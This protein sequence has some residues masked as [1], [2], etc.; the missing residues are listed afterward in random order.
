MSEYVS[1]SI[2]DFHQVLKTEKKWTEHQIGNEIVFDWE[3]PRWPGIVV[4]VYSS[5]KA[6]TGQ[7]RSKGADAIKVCGID[8]QANNG[9]GKG[10]IRSKKVYRVV[11]WRDNLQERVM[12]V[13]HDLRKAFV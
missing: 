1:I 11:N 3:L 6:N 9:R 12:D 13:I 10:L 8:L 4:R 7:S 5:V 2:Q